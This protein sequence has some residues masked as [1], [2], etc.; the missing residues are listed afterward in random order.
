MI[1]I[2]KQPRQPTR[3]HRLA[4]ARRPNEEQVMTT[5]SGHLESEPR[6]R[7]TPHISQV[8]HRR[9]RLSAPA[10]RRISSARPHRPT[11]EHLHQLT[12]R[13]H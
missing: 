1:E 4:S 10:H 11:S 9:Q 6:H 5:S 3:Q 8:V 12:E 13:R 2:G 7:L